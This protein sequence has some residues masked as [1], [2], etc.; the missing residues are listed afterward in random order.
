MLMI[1]TLIFLSISGGPDIPP[2]PAVLT[3]L[4]GDVRIIREGD[5]TAVA[6]TPGDHLFE[7]DSIFAGNGRA[8]VLFLTGAFSVVRK[9]TMLVR[10]LDADTAGRTVLSSDEMKSIR[11]LFHREQG[12]AVPDIVH[13]ASSQDTCGLTIYAPGRT[14]LFTHRP[15]VLWGSV[16]G[17]NW[18][19]VTISHAGVLITDIATTDTFVY[20]P[21]EYDSL[22]SGTFILRVCALHNND[23]LC[24]RE[25]TF[26]I[27]TAAQ[28]EALDRSIGAVTR[29]C[30]DAYTSCLLTAIIYAEHGLKTYAIAAYEDLLQRAPMAFA[31]RELA[32]LHDSMGNE[33]SARQY[34]KKYRSVIS[35]P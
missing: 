29:M 30:P 2:S 34:Y 25:Q 6:A 14:A 5:S 10:V 4:D 16:Q 1:I 32:V 21:D 27:L 35:R 31:L 9:D 11:L 33:E 3:S 13:A 8:T 17:A 12:P 15:D 23:S 28:S 20:Y 22:P 24:R 7:G 26:R 19:A 18:Y